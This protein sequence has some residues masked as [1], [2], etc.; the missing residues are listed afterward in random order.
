MEAQTASIKGRTESFLGN[1]TLEHVDPVYGQRLRTIR[2]E[3]QTTYGDRNSRKI[4][5]TQKEL[6]VRLRLNGSSKAYIS[7]MENGVRPMTQRFRDLLIMYLNVNPDFIDYG[8]KPVFKEAAK[9]ITP[10]QIMLRLDKR[11]KG[12]IGYV[13]PEEFGSYLSSGYMRFFAS[14]LHKDNFTVFELAVPFKFYPP[15]SYLYCTK[16]TSNMLLKNQPVVMISDEGMLAG[17]YKGI[18]EDYQYMLADPERNTTL[19]LPVDD[20]RFFFYIKRVDAPFV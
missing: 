2:T 9:S 4:A 13:L 18:N 8:R 6:A 14:P 16:I 3:L 11:D 15:G 1:Q 19:T 5:V 7:Q 17:L 20:V 10:E 12:N